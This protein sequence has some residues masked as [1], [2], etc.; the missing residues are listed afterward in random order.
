MT[1]I[2]EA[3][4]YDL[5]SYNFRHQHYRGLAVDFRVSDQ[6]DHTSFQYIDSSAQRTNDY[7]TFNNLLNLTINP[8]YFSFSNTDNIQRV[9]KIEVSEQL[10]SQNNN[11]DRFV[12]STDLFSFNNTASLLVNSENRFYYGSQFDLLNVSTQISHAYFKSVQQNSETNSQ[13]SMNKSNTLDW[14]VKIGKGRG[15]LEYIS[16]AVS[17]MFLLQEL[18]EAFGTIYTTEQTIALAESITAIRNQRYL[19]FR[20]GLKHQLQLLDTA[21]TKEG[22]KVPHGIEYFTILNDNWQ[23]AQQTMRQSGKRWTFYMENYGNYGR[24]TNA[25]TISI[26]ELPNRYELS[27]RKN[28][29]LNHDIGIDLDYSTQK[30]LYSEVS[31]GGSL[32]TGIESSL[33]G[34]KRKSDSLPVNISKNFQTFSNFYW[35]SALSFYWQHLYQPNTRNIFISRITSELSYDRQLAYRQDDEAIVRDK[36]MMPIVHIGLT[37]Y[38]WISPH[39]NFTINLTSTYSE[40]I[41]YRFEKENDAKQNSAILRYNGQLGFTYQLF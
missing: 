31:I 39:F 25:N 9:L 27:K 30:S 21:I 37:Y 4:R 19:D 10:G 16:D 38:K 3:Q 35:H 32:S 2:S 1:V 26:S 29:S 41:V 24:N 15:R 36:L 6:G 28:R 8:R 23:Y 20:L 5:N 22:I 12:G 14:N 34:S 11:S 13:S 18:Q 40:E 7:T 33:N 17:A